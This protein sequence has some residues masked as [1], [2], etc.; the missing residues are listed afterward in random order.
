LGE[1]VKVSEDALNLRDL[2]KKFM[3]LWKIDEDEHC[4]LG[5]G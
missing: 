3:K 5:L 4:I 2:M 1:I